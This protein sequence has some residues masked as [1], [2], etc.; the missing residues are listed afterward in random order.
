MDSEIRDFKKLRQQSEEL[1]LRRD[2]FNAN[3]RRFNNRYTR[4]VDQVT[5]IK[6][7]PKED[8]IKVDKKYRGK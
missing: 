4:S 5:I 6:I 8:Y 3:A 1:Q 7:A 2:L